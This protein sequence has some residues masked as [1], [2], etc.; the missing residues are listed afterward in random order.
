MRKIYL[1][2]LSMKIERKLDRTLLLFYYF[3]YL[4]IYFTK[5]IIFIL[6]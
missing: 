6:E 3:Y 2:N 5:S 1:K 4:K